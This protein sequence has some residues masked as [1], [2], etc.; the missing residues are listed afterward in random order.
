MADFTEVVLSGT[1]YQVPKNSSTPPWGEELYDYLIALGIAYSTLIGTGD[2]AEAGF[3][4]ANNQV[5]SAPITGLT[6]DS[7]IIR[8][9]V[10]SYSIYR[11]TATNTLREAGELTIIY[12]PVAAVGTK[13]ALQRD[14]ISD[15]GVEITISDTGVF[16]FTSSNLAGASYSGL[17]RFEAKAI[18]QT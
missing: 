13:W 3:V 1:T 8:S 16:S 7:S 18:L 5:A 6:F 12:D 4:L 2:I 9:A 17:M 11:A 14:S 10:I 15:A